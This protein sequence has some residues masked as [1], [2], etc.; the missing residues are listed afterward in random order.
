MKTILNFRLQLTLPKLIKIHM[1]S[2]SL[3]LSLNS[4]GRKKKAVISQG[5]VITTTLPKDLQKLSAIT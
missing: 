4:S 1:V 5:I 2:I 3:T